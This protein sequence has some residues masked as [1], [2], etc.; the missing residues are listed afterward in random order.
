MQ[1]YEKKFEKPEPVPVFSVF[2]VFISADARSEGTKV[3]YIWMKK[4]NH[5]AET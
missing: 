2:S 4:S 1:E 5:T 3:N